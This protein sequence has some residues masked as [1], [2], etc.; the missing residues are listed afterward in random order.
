V[1][2]RTKV[3]VALGAVYIIWGSTYLAIAVVVETVPPLL[4]ASTRFLAAGAIM[5]VV[6]VRR[7]GTMRVTKAQLGSCVLI[8]CL[9]PGANAV[10]FFAER[11]TPI[12]LASLIIASIPLWVVVLR[13]LLG[14]RL[15]TTVLVGVGIGFAGVAILLQPGKGGVTVGLF[16][17]LLS[18]VMW[19]VGTVAAP[20][21]PMPEDSFAATG[22]EMLAG[23]VVMLPFALTHLGGTSPSV[24]A[25]LGWLYLVTFGSVIGYTAYTWLLANAPLG[26]VSTYAYAN[27]V[28]AILLGLLFRGESLTWRIL[29]GALVVVAAVALVVRQDAPSATQ[30]EEGVR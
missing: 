27:P 24:S 21:L 30:R 9:L 22:W 29:I 18:A 6:V 7:G 8:G 13:L 15:P 28:V 5:A 23:G 10:L 25:I 20:R 19:S 12:G 16:L 4:G 17:C 3:W 11:D 2:H 1:S 14:E 26:L